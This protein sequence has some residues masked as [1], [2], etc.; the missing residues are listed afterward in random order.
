MDAQ[1][2]VRSY[3]AALEAQDLARLDLLVSKDLVF[4]TPLRPLGKQDLLAVFRAIWDGFPDW[5]FNH[6]ELV[7]MDDIVRTKLRMA[8]THTA[9]FVPPLGRLKPVGPTGKRV[10]L[11]EQEF[12]YHVEN[13]RIARIVPENVPGGGI[14]GLLR[15]IGVRLP[16]L[17]LMRLLM[18]VTRLA[19]PNVRT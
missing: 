7:A 17:W 16:P 5:H 11:P 14:P 9:T 8:G 15:Q 18:T 3:L 13:G 6:G 12:V 1:E 4:V 19:R 2:V 10:V